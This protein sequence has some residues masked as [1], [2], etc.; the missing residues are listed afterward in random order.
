MLK[1]DLR[2][3]EPITTQIYQG[4]RR[5]IAAG[6]LKPG[7]P[8]PTVRQLAA[9]L[10]TSLNTVARAYRLLEADGL[11]AAVRGRGTVV[12]EHRCDPKQAKTD[13]DRKLIEQLC[14]A[15]ANARLAGW[16][17]QHVHDVVLAKA[18]SIWPE[19][20]IL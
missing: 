5:E 20:H 12:L 16:S 8:L 14:N 2:D 17:W 1:I 3:P 6:N 9:D 19:E 13:S 18:S 4:I 11:A 7:Q 15:L 10:G